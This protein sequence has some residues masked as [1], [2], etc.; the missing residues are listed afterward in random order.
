MP[1]EQPIEPMA[2]E[3]VA[4]VDPL[5]AQTA[6]KLADVIN[7]FKRELDKRDG[8]WAHAH[9]V[10]DISLKTDKAETYELAVVPHE[11]GDEYPIAVHA[12]PK[13]GHHHLI[14][15]SSSALYQPTRRDSDAKLE[16]D[17]VS[18]KRRKL[19]DADD[20]LRKRLRPDEDEDDLMPLITKEDFDSLLSQL[21]EDIQEDTSECVNHVQKLL[22]RFKEEWHE[23]ATATARQPSRGPFRDSV[24]G[25]GSTPAIA[26][27]PSP[28]LDR[29]DLNIS[30]PDLIHKEAKLVSTQIRWVEECRRVATDIH[31]KRED[32]WRTSS[33]G[34]HDRGRQDRENFQNRMLYESDQQGRVLNQILSEVQAIGLYSQSTKWETP[35]HLAP[36]PVYPPVPTQQAFPAQ[37]SPPAPGT[38]RGQGPGVNKR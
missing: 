15:A 16:R 38:G 28:G 9:G 5:V 31:D 32:N 13:K 10:L 33:A 20:A 3:P 21:R 36:H 22:R 7:D 2:P 37:A 25:N 30:I 6:K 1:D 23:H 35:A 4:L 18:R 8:I 26:A 17:F 27:F 11:Y 19:E 12:R 14:P 24:I 34:F 29:D